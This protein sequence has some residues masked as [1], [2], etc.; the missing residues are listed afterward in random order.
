TVGA[1][2]SQILGI[3]LFHNHVAVDATLTLFPFGT[4]EFRKVRAA[5]WLTFFAEA[6]AS[7]RSFIFTFSPEST[8]DP[9]LIEQMVRSV[10]ERDGKVLFIDL[11]CSRETILR[12]L[13]SEGRAKFGKLTDSVLYQKL[14]A[15][16][17]F[18]FPSLP[19]P[20]LTINTDEVSP[21]AAAGHIAAFL[22]DRLG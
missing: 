1:E 19:E 11:K 2:L 16:G 10:E 8:V 6:A 20:L 3:P 22:H 21:S 7:G 18:K 5:I 4:P 15:E 13:G 17:A 9:A 12:R 14:E